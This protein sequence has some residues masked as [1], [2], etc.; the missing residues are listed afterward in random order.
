MLQVLP[1][2]LSL[3]RPKEAFQNIIYT[4]RT[5]SLESLRTNHWQAPDQEHGFQQPWVVWPALIPFFMLGS[6]KRLSL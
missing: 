5:P 6:L 2:P 4:F 1:I 3:L